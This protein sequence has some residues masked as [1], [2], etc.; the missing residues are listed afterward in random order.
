MLLNTAGLRVCKHHDIDVGDYKFPPP[1]LAV[2]SAD[3]S[4]G[5]LFYQGIVSQGFWNSEGNID[6]GDI[7]MG[8]YDD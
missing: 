3:L 6:H 1:P 4:V 5:A 8:G 7:I 2:V